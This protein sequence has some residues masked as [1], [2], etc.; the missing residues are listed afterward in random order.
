MEKLFD[1]RYL[2]STVV[3]KNLFWV[4]FF[5]LEVKSPPVQFGMPKTVFSDNCQSFRVKESS[6]SEE[7]YVSTGIK[8]EAGE[9][10]EQSDLNTEELNLD[11]LFSGNLKERMTFEDSSLQKRQ[12][13]LIG[14]TDPVLDSYL[15]FP[16]YTKRMAG[17]I[18][19]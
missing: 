8:V 5:K 14:L 3:H 16:I 1:S 7:A 6:W 11:N 18:Y 2:V 15:Y 12:S 17:N 13:Y 4:N 10:D 19:K 9:E